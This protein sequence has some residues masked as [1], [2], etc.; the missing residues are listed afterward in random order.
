MPELIS[1]D[2]VGQMAKLSSLRLS[3]EETI[4][5]QQTLNRIL[6]WLQQ[7]EEVDSQGAAQTSHIL[8]LVN[9]LRPD[10]PIPSLPREVALANAPAQAEGC[11]KVP[12]IL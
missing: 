3:P 1:P 11:F 12:K 7:I 9:V 6:E 8:P 4:T 10:Q 2:Q 5:Y